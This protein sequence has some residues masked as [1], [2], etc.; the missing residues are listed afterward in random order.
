M[1][2]LRRNL[3]TNRKGLSIFHLYFLPTHVQARYSNQE[4]TN[5]LVFSFPSQAKQFQESNTILIYIPY[6]F[7][8][9][10]S[11]RLVI[12]TS[13]VP[14]QPWDSVCP[15]RALPSSGRCG[16]AFLGWQRWAATRGPSCLFYT[17]S[18]SHCVFRSLLTLS[19]ISGAFSPCTFRIC[20]LFEL[21]TLDICAETTNSYDK[22]IS[23]SVPKNLLDTDSKELQLLTDT[24]D[25]F[26][27]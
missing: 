9:R 17:L 22:L 26:S 10:I 2:L 16:K 6:Y 20:L 25:Y 12:P 1:C 13:S 24:K 19:E 7:Y 23:K 18:D 21:D 14:G 8:Q 3:Q 5:K 11:S 15:D 4:R 27:V